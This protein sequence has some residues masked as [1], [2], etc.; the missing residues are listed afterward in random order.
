MTDRVTAYAE[1]ILAGKSDFPVGKD[2]IA[3]CRR[4][5]EDLRRQ[6]TDEFP[7]YWDADAGDRVLQF[8]ESLTIAE[9]SEPRPVRLYGSQIFDIGCQ[10][11]WKRTNGKRR[12]R[13]CY[14]SKARQNGK[15]FE[16]GIKGPYIAAFS[17]YRYGK[18]FCAATKKRQ[19]R[20][21]W[22]EMSKFISADPDLAELFSIKDYKSLI[23]AVDTHCTIEALSKESGLDDGFRSIFSSID[24]IHQ[25]RDNKIYKALYNGTKKVPETLV[26][27]ITTRGENP[28]SFCK[29]I[30]DYAKKILH[31]TATAEDFFVD[32]YCPDE[33]DDIH[34]ERTWMKAN[35]ILVYDADAWEQFRQDARTAFDMGGQDLKDFIIKSLNLWVK[36]T[37]DQAYDPDAWK[38]CGSDRTIEQITESGRRKCFV[39]LDLSS[40]GDLTSLFIEIDAT[41]TEPLYLYS[42]SFIPAGRLQEH[43]ETDVAP[44]DLWHQ[45]GLLTA[46]G[47]AT[48]FMTDYDFILDHLRELR[49]RLGLEFAGI[50]IDPHNAS[51]LMQ[52]LEA[53][54][55]CPI[56][57]ITQ[58]AR[59]LNDATVDT[60]NLVKSRMV[61]YD[62][63]N[64]LLTWS[65]L[66]AAIVHNSFKEIKLDKKPGARTQRIDVADSWIDAHALRL[67]NGG[68]EQTDAVLADGLAEYL[69]I[70]G[71]LNK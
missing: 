36:N 51:A 45:N 32:I 50:G 7:Y 44:Y 39:G 63:Q 29:E 16:N 35:P 53:E 2:H 65:I 21:A 27:M 48:S 68:S 41:A 28:N 15:T 31:G 8:A 38:A 12:F 52:R 55:G 20:L 42:H 3:A 47:S 13:R 25:H 18:L 22:E 54:F 67:I 6:N 71:G 19:A 17:G 62:R 37:E 24:E 58:S 23:E 69:R 64:E 10:F 14:I 60:R 40:G 46:T 57:T 9:G 11:G 30:D 70:Y 49:D 5:I 59:A 26:S 61:E 4:H 33:G 56:V 66:N 34:D 43:V 1:R